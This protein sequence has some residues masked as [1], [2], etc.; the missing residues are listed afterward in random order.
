MET[1]ASRK[2]N[3]VATSL[4]TKIPGSEPTV[5]TPGPGWRVSLCSGRVT[6]SSFSTSNWSYYRQGTQRKPSQTQEV[7]SILTNSE[8]KPS[9]FQGSSKGAN[10]GLS[11]SHTSPWSS[12]YRAKASVSEIP[13][14]FDCHCH[15]WLPTVGMGVLT[16]GQPKGWPLRH[17][18]RD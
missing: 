12:H 17:Q 11:W 9:N 5:A 7:H 16:W 13:I 10:T 6:H 2:H 4:T 18:V 14:L 15:N 1:Q 8:E 3:T